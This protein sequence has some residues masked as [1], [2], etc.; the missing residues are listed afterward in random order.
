MRKAAVLRQPTSDWIR[1]SAMALIINN[2]FRRSQRQDLTVVFNRGLSRRAVHAL[3]AMK[4]VL[5]VEPQRTVPVEIGLGH[6]SYRTAITVLAPETS[7]QR[8]LSIDGTVVA[9]P[10]TGITLTE[11][12]GLTIGARADD[13]VA[14]KVLEGRRIDRLD[15]VSVLKTKE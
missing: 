7:L 12:L 6:R 8:I 14:V 4:G 11:T 15:L 2:Q 9:V 5:Q 13:I 3:R 1:P 10:D